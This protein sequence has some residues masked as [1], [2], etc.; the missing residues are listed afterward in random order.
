MDTTNGRC[1]TYTYRGRTFELHLRPDEDAHFWVAILDGETIAV[2]DTSE[3]C[4]LEA[5]GVLHQRSAE[6]M[7]PADLLAWHLQRPRYL[8]SDEVEMVVGAGL[9]QFEDF[10]GTDGRWLH[11]DID[12]EATRAVLDLID[13]LGRECV[14]LHSIVRRMSPAQLDRAFRW[15][16]TYLQDDWARVTA[17]IA[18]L[19]G[20]PDLLS[21]AGYQAV[22]LT[23]AGSPHIEAE[24][25]GGIAVNL[26]P[27]ERFLWNTIHRVTHVLHYLEYET[28]CRDWERSDQVQPRPKHVPHGLVFTQR[29]MSL[30]DA[31]EAHLLDLGIEH[32]LACVGPQAVSEARK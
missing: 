12:G 26:P 11:V 10:I 9:A 32:C 14:E 3:Q 6:P 28:S 1:G 13:D 25:Y 22:R 16:Q 8:R 17:D 24:Y 21:R 4:E 2:R 29:L 5:K 31:V 7:E 19:G 23:V 20:Y 18:E 27:G 30:A 15:S